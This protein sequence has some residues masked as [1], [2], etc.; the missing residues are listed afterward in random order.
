M[1]ILLEEN[2]AFLKEQINRKDKVI[3]SLLNQLS[4]KNDSTQHNK[5]S[6]TKANAISIQTE[7]IADSK[8]TESS[9]KREHSRKSTEQK[10]N[11]TYIDPEQPTPLH[12]NAG[13][14]SAKKNAG[15]SEDNSST[16]SHDINSKSKKSIVILGDSMLKQLNRWKMS[17][18]V[19]NDRKILV[20][21]FS[22]AT[23]IPESTNHS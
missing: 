14:S 15:N 4:R 10:Q 18:K 2:T 23:V 12:N 1:T 22:G 7:L 13:T 6:N 3:D 5:T 9:K 8:S 16:N 19:K 21:H 17:K 20:K 11:L